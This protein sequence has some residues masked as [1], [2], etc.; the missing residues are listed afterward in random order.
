VTVTQSAARCLPLV[1]VVVQAAY[2]A[3][4]MALHDLTGVAGQPDSERGLDDAQRGLGT[5]GLNT[6]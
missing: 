1:P 6:A 4:R 5:L 3:W 2:F